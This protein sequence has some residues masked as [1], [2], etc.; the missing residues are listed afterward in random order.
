V[1][2]GAYSSPHGA[3]DSERLDEL[4]RLTDTAGADVVG[5]VEQVRP[6]PDPAFYIGS[7]KVEELAQEVKRLRADVVIFD[8]ELKP[9]QVRNLES[10]LDTKVIDRTELILHIFAHHARTS[11]AQLQVELA[12]LEYIYPRL[13][14]M[15]R[16]LEKI[17]GGIGTRGP[18]ERQIESDRRIVRKRIDTLRKKLQGV[19]ARRAREVQARSR[20]VTACLVGYTNA[21]KSSLMNALTGTNVRVE[22]TLFSTLD[23]RTGRWEIGPGR[24]VLLSDTVGFIRKLPHHLVASFY[25]T[26]EE[27]RQADLLLHVVDASSPHARQQADTVN[28]VLEELGC[29]NHPRLLALNKCDLLEDD[30]ILPFFQRGD[31]QAIL[32]S[33]KTGAQLDQLRAKVT[34]FLD[35]AMVRTA[36]AFDPG[37]GKLQ[38]FLA[39]RAQ[40]VSKKYSG[41]AASFEVVIRP[42]DLGAVRKLGGDIRIIQASAGR[43]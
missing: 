5:R 36:V 4:A 34:R 29:T 26:L 32:V 33:A 11:A 22:D 16:H 9:S 24:T 12:Q 38:A 25:A 37:N 8:V 14:H 6:S 40:I 2:V 10:A 21:G 42:I 43:R 31:E 27:V 35:E 13:I 18:G 30:S 19:E 3:G 17:E 20:Q 15:W 28:G 41:T 1:L 23:T 7:G 39:S